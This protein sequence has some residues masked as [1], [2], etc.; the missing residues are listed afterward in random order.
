MKS[1]IS[2]IFNLLLTLSF[3]AGCERE[4]RPTGISGKISSVSLC[5]ND[6]ST[7]M[8]SE[9]GDSQSCI[10]YTYNQAENMLLLKHINAGFNCC[11]DSLSCDI[12]I[13]GDTITI[14]EIESQ[15]LCNCNCLYDVDFELEGVEADNFYIRI[16]EPYVE[17]MDRLS[18]EIDLS[19]N[20]SGMFCVARNGY[21]WGQP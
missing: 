8:L 12:T 20:P 3:I 10:Q 2:F 4:N 16:I 1:Q 19:E 17:N 6:K 13:A 18:G 9:I 11:Y 7:K 5:K 15:P 14:E 21:P